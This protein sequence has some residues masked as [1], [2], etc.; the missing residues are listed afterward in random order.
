M[1]FDI[2]PPKCIRTLS[3]GWSESDTVN[4]EVVGGVIE[5]NISITDLETL[6][7]GH[8][9]SASPFILQTGVSQGE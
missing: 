1:K 5:F 3:V 9:R 4:Q 8:D 6:L 7:L 2:E